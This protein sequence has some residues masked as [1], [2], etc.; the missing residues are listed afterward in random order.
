MQHFDVF[1]S[2]LLSS[3]LQA[4]LEK[5][6]IFVGEYILNKSLKPKVSKLIG[7]TKLMLHQWQIIFQ[8]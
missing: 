3:I 6:I 5:N 4:V 1:N 2:I 7:L 8:L